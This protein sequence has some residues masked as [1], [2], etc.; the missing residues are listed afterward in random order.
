MSTLNTT[1]DECYATDIALRVELGDTRSVG[2]CRPAFVSEGKRYCTSCG[3]RVHA[4]VSGTGHTGRMIPVHQNCL[5][6][7]PQMPS[8]VQKECSM[9]CH[10]YSSPFW[11]ANDVF[12]KNSSSGVKCI[13]NYHRELFTT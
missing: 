7:W 2:L 3:F 5:T 13:C 1:L 8:P 11:C 9:Q 12:S 6:N 10:C 4:A